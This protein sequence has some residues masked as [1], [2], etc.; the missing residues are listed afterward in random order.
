MTGSTAFCKAWELG[1]ENVLVNPGGPL[2]RKD[3][4]K[5]G[6]LQNLGT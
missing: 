5:E 4:C 2:K 6:I 1:N 3:F